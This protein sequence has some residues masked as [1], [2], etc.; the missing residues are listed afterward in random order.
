M[1]FRADAQIV[2][3]AIE[4]EPPVRYNMFRGRIGVTTRALY[5][6]TLVN[7]IVW[8]GVTPLPA[9]LLGRLGMRQALAPVQRWWARG[10]QRALAI[11]LDI[12][13]LEQIDPRET[14]IVAPLHEGFADA[15]AL[16]QLP[17]ALRFVVRDEIGEWR[18]IGPY[19]HDTE[20]II[21]CPEEGRRS[22]RHLVTEAQ[23]SVAR[24]E[25]VVI[26]PQGSILGIE[27]DFLRGAF[28]L[29]RTLHCPILPVALTGSHRVWEHP[30]TT[31]LRYGQRMSMRVLAPIAA[32]DVAAMSSEEMRLL[33]QRRLKAAAL[34]GTMAPP[35]RFV[36]TRDGYWDGYAYQI[37]PQ[38]VE[39]AADIAQH[40]ASVKR[41]T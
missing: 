17:L 20:Q 36:P 32:E 12:S 40:R 2:R 30:Y 24:G 4:H 23:R 18:Y 33:V 34:D 3:A 11:D 26:F 27:T 16:L 22:Y 10:I 21:I 38:F 35:R 15:V 9:R 1:T 39:L 5:L 31:R 41:K 29:A 13:G 14:Y 8:L 28:A 37:D 19:L 6:R 7:A 25:S